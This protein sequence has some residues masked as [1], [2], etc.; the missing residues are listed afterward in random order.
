MEN[1]QHTHIFD[2]GKVII[3]L[4]EESE[5]FMRLGQVC[6]E[7]KLRQLSTQ[8]FF[9]D[10]EKGLIA[11][12]DFIQTLHH[13]SIHPHTSVQ[14]IY[15]AWNSILLDI[16]PHRIAL[17]KQLKQTQQV[18]LLSNTNCIHIP[19]IITY[20]EQT[21]QEDIFET[22]FHRAYFSYELKDRKPHQSIYEKVLEL[23]NLS[24]EKC[25]FYDDK[26]ENLLAPSNLGIHCFLVNRDICTMID[27]M[28]EPI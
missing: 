16:P 14:Q 10:F 7:Q 22:C 13:A 20:C 18:L 25:S 23:E 11:E 3:N 1:N 2:L 26:A 12:E 4:L 5:W 17:L 19:Q 21:F 6:Q 15:D 8:G 28:G 27:V 9:D 24:P